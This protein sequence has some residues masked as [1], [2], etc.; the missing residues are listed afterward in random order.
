MHLFFAELQ[1]NVQQRQRVLFKVVHAKSVLKFII[2][3]ELRMTK[4]IKRRF[5]ESFLKPTDRERIL[6]NINA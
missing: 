5:H 4:M 2:F 1:L 6:Q 3:E